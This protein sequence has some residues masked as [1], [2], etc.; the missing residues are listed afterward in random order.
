MSYIET[1]TF[2]EVYPT[3]TDFVNSFRSSVM[4]DYIKEDKYLEITYAL[5]MS[6]YENSHIASITA[7]SFKG[8]VNSVIFQYGPT[9][10]KQLEMQQRLINLTEA[11][12]QAGTIAKSTAGYNPSNVPG[13]A[14]S[15]TEIETV[16]QQSLQKY[17]KSKLDAYS[18]LNELLKVNVTVNY[19]NQFKKLFMSVIDVDN[20]LEVYIGGSY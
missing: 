15:D 2:V 12:L 18:G 19:L 7:D 1:K 11:E 3:S 6:K 4:T 17:T 10:I 8:K 16:N 20:I 9:W 13:T 5:L 14:N